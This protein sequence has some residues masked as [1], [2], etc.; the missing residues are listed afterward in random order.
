MLA[1]ALRGGNANRRSTF[2]VFARQLP[3]SPLR[4]GRRNR[5]AAGTVAEFRFDD[6]ACLLLAQFLDTDTMATS[7]ISGLA[8]TSTATRRA[9]CTSRIPHTLGAR[10]FRRVRGDR[11][12]GV[13]DLQPRC[14]DRHSGGAHGQRRRGPPA[15]RDGLPANPRACGGRGGPGGLY[16]RL[17]GVVQPGGPAPLR[18]THG[19]HRRACLHHAAHGRTGPDE[20]AAFRAQ[21]DALG[22]ETTLL[23]DTYDVT[24]GVANAVA[25]AGASSARSASTP[26]SS[27]CWR[28][29]CARSSTGWGPRRPASWCP[30]IWTSSPS[31]RCAR[32]RSTAT[33]SARR[34]SPGRARRPRT[35]STNWSRST[36]F[37]CRSAAATRNPAA[38]T[39][40]RCG[41]HARPAPSPRRSCIRPAVHP[42]LP[43]RPGS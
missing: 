16:R 33:A 36:A 29:R 18:N 37:R 21:V 28:G 32:S 40:R 4:S 5:P 26:A 39:R 14:R 25:A 3:R 34:W 43:N 41:C 10:Q 17:R 27:E 9:S 42:P 2:E 6:D 23:V 22:T 35:W 31:R 7:G 15:D 19:R 12:A 24:T 1:A 8:A 13:V 11:N 38:A 30:A 20:L